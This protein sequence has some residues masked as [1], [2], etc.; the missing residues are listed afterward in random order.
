MEEGDK[1]PLSEPNTGT[2]AL[3]AHARTTIPPRGWSLHEITAVVST[4]VGGCHGLRL[5]CRSARRLTAALNLQ[6]TGLTQNLG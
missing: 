6:F 4:V 5:F 2:R 3:A 1:T